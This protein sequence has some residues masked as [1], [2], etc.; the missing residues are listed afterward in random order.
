V[1][2]TIPAALASAAR[3]FG[4]AQALAE[5]DGARLSDCYEVSSDRVPD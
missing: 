5:P 1:E 4:G 3:E 2:L